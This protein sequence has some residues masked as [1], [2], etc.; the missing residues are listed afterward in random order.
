LPNTV[1][2]PSFGHLPK[3]SKLKRHSKSIDSVNT[4]L[5]I[6]D[7]DIQFQKNGITFIWNTRKATA[8]PKKHDGITFEQAPLFQR[9][10]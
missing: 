9:G 5:G 3:A 6:T 1:W 2:Q 8:N 4:L 10:G 7:M